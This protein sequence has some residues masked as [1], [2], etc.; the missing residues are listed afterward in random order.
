MTKNN[1]QGNSIVVELGKGYV[2]VRIG[3]M[4]FKLNTSDSV[5]R[6]YR[7]MVKK[8]DP[9]MK[10]L[11]EKI[12]QAIKDD[13]YDSELECIGLSVDICRKVT[14]VILGSGSFDQLYAA[15]NEDSEAV[16]EAVLEVQSQYEKIKD[17]SKLTKLVASKKQG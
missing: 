10:A 16:I 9:E 8:L 11:E 12:E 4:E 1:N 13:D 5:I 2:P 17:R 15:S 14:D 3:G 7:S 6:K